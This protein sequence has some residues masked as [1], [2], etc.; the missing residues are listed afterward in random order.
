VPGI[1]CTFRALGN[2]PTH[3]PSVAN[4]NSGQSTTDTTR[5]PPR[6]GPP[7]PQAS[8][9][10]HFHFRMTASNYLDSAVKYQQQ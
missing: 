5:Q 7:L 2:W 6:L 8:D 1:S 9:V 3:C 10:P 4:T